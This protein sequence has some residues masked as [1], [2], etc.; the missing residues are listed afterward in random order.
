[1][2]V[3][4]ILLEDED[5]VRGGIRM[6]LDADP[7][8]EVVAEDGDGANATELVSKHRPDVVLTDIQMPVVGGLEVTRRLTAL[9]NAPAVA[10]LT[11]FDLDE[12][13]HAALR[14]GAAGFLLKDTPPREL[15]SA[16]HVVASGEAMLSPRITTK[17]LSSFAG[18]SNTPAAK[19]RTA[20]LTAREREV[21]VAVAQG[22]NN[23][24]IA[25]KLYMSQSTVK[26]HLGQIMT[27]LDAANRTQVAI[28]THD[29]GLA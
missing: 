27:K 24:D 20:E 21:A 4:V 17:L 2:S 29:A 25:S 7:D 12:Y 10:L 22:L 28:T 14:D 6:I 5:L 13:V 11:T 18:N 16:V 1:M 15:A 8:I 19:A 23:A 26:A 9:P 3:K